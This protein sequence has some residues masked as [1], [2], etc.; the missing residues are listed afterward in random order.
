MSAVLKT[1]RCAHRIRSRRH[2]HSRGRSTTT[3]AAFAPTTSGNDPRTI[4]PPQM[5]ADSQRWSH[6]VS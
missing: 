6:I 5:W 2:S 3:A 4:P 1:L